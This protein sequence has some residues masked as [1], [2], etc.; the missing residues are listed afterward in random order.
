MQRDK[1]KPKGKPFLTVLQL[2]QHPTTTTAAAA[3]PAHASLTSFA[4]CPKKLQ[5]TTLLPPLLPCPKPRAALVSWQPSAS[6]R[7]RHCACLRLCS[8]RAFVCRSFCAR[9]AFI[10][11]PDATRHISPALPTSRMLRCLC[12]CYCCCCCCLCAVAAWASA[13][14]AAAAFRRRFDYVTF[15]FCRS[16]AAAAAVIIMRWLCLTATPPATV[17]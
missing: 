1:P 12:H 13:F 6:A 14:S 10:L 4:A 11:L 17:S 16:A 8:S 2:L 3:Q 9:R 5:G 15:F 7:L